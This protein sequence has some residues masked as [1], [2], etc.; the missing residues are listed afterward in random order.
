MNL[1]D[2]LIS[3]PPRDN[4][5]SLSSNAFDYQKDW[6]ICKLLEEHSKKSDYV[7]I[8]D[9]HDD[10]VMLDSE[11][12][13]SK[14]QFYQIKTK[15]SGTWTISSLLKRGTSRKTQTQLPS[16]L[17]KL[18]DNFIKFPA[19][20]NS[21]FFISNAPYK[22]QLSDNSSSKSKLIVCFKNLTKEELEKIKNNLSIELPEL[23]MQKC[24][25]LTYLIVSDLSL[26]DHS[27]HTLG[28][29]TIFLQEISPG[30][31]DNQLIYKTL[32]DEVKRKTNK[33]DDTFDS[34][35]E[36]IK[37]KGISRRQFQEI[38]DK[39]LTTKDQPN[40]NGWQQIENRLNSEKI[41]IAQIT[42][43]R[44]NYRVLVIDKMKD[45]ALL[46]KLYEEFNKIKIIL[47]KDN[48]LDNDLILCINY[49][50]I[51][52][53]KQPLDQNIY[54]SDFLKVIAMDLIYNEQR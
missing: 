48:K 23:D 15:N 54:N 19:F 13:P 16:I 8:L 20:T 33:V 29:L 3:I 37:K 21:L 5:G 25:N 28:K 11:L 43:Y 22:V 52:Y 47:N 45:N 2:A 39:F 35:E 18:Y 1:S 14:I 32:F 46:D 27:T 6:A 40:D 10:L 4:S 12:T 50:M 31:Y 38:V 42:S 41:S 7:F 36:M 9:F 49:F 44:N 30:N 34:L 53:N 51:E 26:N 24:E 17:G